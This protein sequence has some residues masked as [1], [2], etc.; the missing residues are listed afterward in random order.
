MR[1]LRQSI[2]DPNAD[3]PLDY[4]SVSVT[5]AKGKTTSGIHLNEDEYS[6]HLRDLTGNLRSF[7]KSEL[8]EITLP[9]QSLMPAYPS[10]SAADL[11]NLV[12]YLGSLR[13]AR[14]GH[15]IDDS[16][17]RRRD[18]AGIVRRSR[19]RDMIRRPAIRHV[20]L[21]VRPAG[22]H[23]RPQ[24]DRAGRA[25]GH[26]LAAR[27]SGRVRRRG[28]CAVHRQPSARGRQRRSRGRRSSGPTAAR[29]SSGGF[30]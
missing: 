19:R 10:L 6:V 25:Q 15:D 13:P 12:A 8:K 26:R 1:H 11:E 17:P 18:R 5:D 27:Q 3:L 28:R 23:R 30:T 22:E 21:D 4:R 9:R 29:A 20:S 16:C 24:D 7:M 14:K 2:V